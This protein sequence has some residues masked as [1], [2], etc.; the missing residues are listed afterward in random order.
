[1]KIIEFTDRKAG[2]KRYV[3]AKSKSDAIA[4]VLASDYLIN[5]LSAKE[6]AALIGEDIKI[7]TVEDGAP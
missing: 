5:A 2:W 1:M 6:I 3:K 7:E 4:H